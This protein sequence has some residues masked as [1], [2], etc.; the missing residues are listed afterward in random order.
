MTT[1]E[2]ETRDGLEDRLR[3]ESQR[4][5]FV[6]CGIAPATE[7]DTYALYRCWLER[8]YA[9]EMQY[10]QRRAEERRHPRS[11]LA[12][13][14]SVV[15]LA[16]E[17]GPRPVRRSAPLRGCVAGRVALYAHG[18]DYHP[19]IWERL[20]QLGQWLNQQVPGCECVGVCDTAPLLER[21]F[22]RRAG[23]GWIGKNTLLIHPRRGSF[24]FLAALL[25]DCVL[26]P[27]EPFMAQHCGTCTACI[28][29][30]PTGAI[31]APHLLDATRCISYLTIEH[32]SAIPEALAEQIGDWL[33]GCDICQEVCPWNR[34]PRQTESPFPY[35]AEREWLDP[36]QIL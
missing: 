34:K 28:Q 31:V 29:A 24:L 7:A 32:R 23:L 16:M 30:C 21:D 10:L 14:R 18:P 35:Q 20:R 1:A 5:G 9:G 22:A 26:Q 3:A 12:S 13:V 27:D 4:L 6:L 36:V 15:M 8:G 19:F 25:T 2:T 33:F 11:I 17:Y